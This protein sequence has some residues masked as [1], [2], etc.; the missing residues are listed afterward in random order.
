MK[1]K[2]MVGLLV[3]ATLSAA[4]SVQAFNN[5]DVIRFKAGEES[6]RVGDTSCYYGTVVQKGSY[7]AMDTNGNGSF[8]DYERVAITPGSDGGFVVGAIQAASGSHGG[9]PDGSEFAPIDAPWSF[10][11]NTGMH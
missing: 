3:I 10:F 9:N 6:C 5:G 4:S 7:F 1:N 8:S 2:K 11:G